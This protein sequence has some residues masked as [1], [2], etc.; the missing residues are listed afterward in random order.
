MHSPL[1][2]NVDAAIQDANSQYDGSPFLDNV[3]AFYPD[4]PTSSRSTSR[5]QTLGLRMAEF[6]S[7]VSDRPPR[8]YYTTLTSIQGDIVPDFSAVQNA[9][10]LMVT[11]QD[12]WDTFMDA[13]VVNGQTLTGHT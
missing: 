8:L 3:F 13:V 9:A 5:E 10:K 11:G 2:S 6:S 7:S 4:E 12:R 1:L